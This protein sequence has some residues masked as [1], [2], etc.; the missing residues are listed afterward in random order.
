MIKKNHA[1]C[2]SEFLD[3]FYTLRI[4]NLLN[5]LVVVEVCNFGRAIKELKTSVVKV[6]LILL[7][8]NVLD[9]NLMCICYRV[10]IIIT[11]RRVQVNLLIG[12]CTICRW[13]LVYNSGREC[14]GG[15]C[16]GSGSSR[17]HCG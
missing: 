10:P 3:K 6:V 5:F 1:G 12:T 14:V 11:L 8:A 17:R 9:L 13:D 16:D 4:I 7:L 15:D 2:T